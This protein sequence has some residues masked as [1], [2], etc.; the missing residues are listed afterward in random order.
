MKAMVSCAIGA[1]KPVDI[2]SGGIV[3]PSHEAQA[4]R[5]DRW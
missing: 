3:A 4:L 5:R 1:R 2:K